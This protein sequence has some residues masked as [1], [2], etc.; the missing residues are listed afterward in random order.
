MK[1]N[2]P[3]LGEIELKKIGE[4]SKHGQGE[5]VVQTIYTDPIGD[6]HIETWTTTNGGD[7]S[8]TSVIRKDII[9]KI[10][11]INSKTFSYTKEEIEKLLLA[12]MIQGTINAT[13]EQACMGIKMDAKEWIKQNLK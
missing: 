13:P 7:K 4:L 12:E 10:N 3:F 1:Y 9:D 5:S 8:T 2:H 6:Y 11:E